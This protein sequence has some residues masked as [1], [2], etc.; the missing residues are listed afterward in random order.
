MLRVDDIRYL[1]ILFMLHNIL[2]V[3]RRQQGRNSVVSTY[4]GKVD[5]VLTNYKNIET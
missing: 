3:G 2:G 1:H 4:V 5:V